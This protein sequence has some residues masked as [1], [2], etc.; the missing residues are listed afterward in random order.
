MKR[1]VTFVDGQ[2]LFHS[3]REAFGYTYPNYN[4]SALAKEYAGF[5]AVSGVGQAPQPH[6]RALRLDAPREIRHMRL[7]P[8]RQALHTRSPEHRSD[9]S[10]NGM[11]DRI[12]PTCLTPNEIQDQGSDPRR[13]WVSDGYEKGY[14][15]A[16]LGCR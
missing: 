9:K 2:N 6:P 5:T 10:R 8:L 4:V 3:A 11:A 12:N 13:Q 14:C 1:A 7:A 15:S 16:R